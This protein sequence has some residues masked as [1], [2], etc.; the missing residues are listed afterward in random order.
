MFWVI[1]TSTNHAI[2]ISTMKLIFFEGA[3]SDN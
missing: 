3:I 2:K 1:E